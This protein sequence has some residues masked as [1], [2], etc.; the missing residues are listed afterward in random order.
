MKNVLALIFASV[1]LLGCML[2][3]ASC[4]E[5]TPAL[6]YDDAREAL[7]EEGYRLTEE[8]DEG[9]EDPVYKYKLVGSGNDGE[10]YIEMY[11]FESE[12]VAKLYLKKLEMEKDHDVKQL[13]FEINFL[14]KCMKEHKNDYRNAQL[15]ELE[16]ELEDLKEE[17]KIV[18]KEEE[19]T[20]GRDGNVV[21]A[22]TPGAIADSRG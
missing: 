19:W 18:K 14:K 6:N 5:K 2:V 9:D 12:E 7:E 20:F 8:D 15:K 11:W 16:E 1:M 4:E 3:F 13:E 21:W 17:L 22:G 10:E